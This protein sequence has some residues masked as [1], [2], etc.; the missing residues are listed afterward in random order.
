MEFKRINPQPLRLL[1]FVSPLRFFANPS[2]LLPTVSY[3]IIFA[4]ANIFPSVEIGVLYA[5][6]LHFNSQQIG[7]QNISVIIGSL[8]GELIGGFLSDH[9][10]LLKKKR[11]G[12]YPRPEWRLWLSYIAYALSIVGITVFLVCIEQ[13]HG[14]WTIDPQVGITVAAV[15]NQIATTVLITYAVDCYHLEAAAIGVF[16]NFIRQL[17]GF[18]GPFW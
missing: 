17:W 16:I 6:L 12:V 4:F 9:W 3:S 1:D 14:N 15:G 18:I 2:I 8:I 10:M 5:E 11:T 13:D 7:L